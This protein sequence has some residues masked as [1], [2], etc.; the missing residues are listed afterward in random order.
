MLV[1]GRWME[2]GLRGD[3]FVDDRLM[4]DGWGDERR[5][6]LDSR[7]VAHQLRNEIEDRFWQGWS[8]LKLLDLPLQSTDL[9]FLSLQMDWVWQ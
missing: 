9:V 3:R 2:V 5:L 1:D 6:G 8:R 4:G 7:W